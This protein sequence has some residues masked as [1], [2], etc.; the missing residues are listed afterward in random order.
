MHSN[1]PSQGIDLSK[2]RWVVRATL[3]LT[4][5]AKP[6][7]EEYVNTYEELDRVVNDFVGK[8][9]CVYILPSYI[10]AENFET[11]KAGMFI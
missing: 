10:V 6:E 5:G 9:L 2:C 8:G 11:Y 4:A 3:D 7:G 1:N